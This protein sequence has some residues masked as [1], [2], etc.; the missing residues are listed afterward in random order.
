M[1]AGLLHWGGTAERWIAVDINT[2][3]DEPALVFFRLGERACPPWRTVQSMIGR[4]DGRSMMTERR[5]EPQRAM[6]AILSD[7]VFPEDTNPY[8]TMFGG[9]AY[10]MMDKA[11]FLAANRFAHTL[12]V[13]ASSESIDFNVPIRVGM[14]L[15]AVA[16]VVFTG[17]TSMVVRVTLTCRAPLSTE[18]QQATVGYFTMV[19]VDETG[20]PIAVPPLLVEDQA[21]W[22]HAERIRAA[23]VARRRRHNGGA[24]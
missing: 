7:I 18:E 16:Q 9:H 10:A 19:A 3:D 22:D 4:K 21:E 2:D 14:I 5:A 6:P 20:A 12:A 8:G 15:E 13:T 23:A 17:R 24:G 1:T 11:A